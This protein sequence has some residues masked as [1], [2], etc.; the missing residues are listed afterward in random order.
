MVDVAVSRMMGLVVVARLAARHGVKVELRPAPERGTVA[1]VL[2]PTVVLVPRAV[3]GRGPSAGAP[4]GREVPPVRPNAVPPPRTPFGT[5]LA[6][7]S[8]PTAG[9]RTPAG[10]GSPGPSMGGFGAGPTAFAGPSNYSGPGPQAPA[11]PPGS[12]SSFGGFGINR[13]ESTNGRGG[14]SDAGHLPP[15][16]DLTGAA[17]GVNGTDPYPTR[18]TPAPPPPPPPG[19]LPQR[20]AA[21][22]PVE[23]ELAEDDRVIPRQ[24]PASPEAR[25]ASLE[26]TGVIEAVDADLVEEHHRPTPAPAAAP[27]PP[28]W[29]P[30][31]T[32]AAEPEAAEAPA[33]PV[34]EALA[35]ALDITSEMP[36][37]RDRESDGVG[38]NAGSGAPGPVV[39]AAY[40]PPLSAPQQEPA[41]RLVVP[42]P[43]RVK[44]YADETMEL[45]IFREL[46]SAWFR[47]RSAADASLGVQ[48]PVAS[49]APAAPVSAPPAAAPP[50]AG[51]PV[52]APPVVPQPAKR[53]TV[54]PPPAPPSAVPQAATPPPAV[55][56]GGPANGGAQPAP[57]STTGTHKGTPPPS[58]GRQPAP[59]PGWRTAADD[60]WVAAS[61]AADPQADGITSAGLP[62]RVPMAQLVPGGVDRGTTNAN[63]RSPEQVRGLLSAYHRGVQRGRG[64]RGGDDAKTPESTTSGHNPPGGKEQDG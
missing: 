6:L 16:S 48:Q 35:A 56:Y 30:V 15:W 51:P 20:R 47:T 9:G 24:V 4:L 1:D 22:R 19:P 28:A 49:A 2:L 31:P 42:E 10:A 60:G 8:G 63:R 41:E 53:P 36:R 21:D 25:P 12:G 50:A 18:R 40:T 44:A 17:G 3:G 29:P 34:P 32:P 61:Q 43:A 59:E 14:A 58:A 26:D 13:A 7:E 27:P 54:P 37:I 45:P 57:G 33:P 11:G 55:P 39:P 52:A 64:G 23:G 62:R 38:W 5:P 46:E